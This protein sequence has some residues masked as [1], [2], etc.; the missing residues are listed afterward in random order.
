METTCWHTPEVINEM[1]RFYDLY[2]GNHEV[3]KHFNIFTQLLTLTDER[4][5][6]LLDLGCGTAMLS[7]YCKEYKYIGAD[8]PHIISGC[9]MRN[10][11]KY[12]FR[13]CDL[14]NDDLSWIN[15]Y[16]VISMNAVIDVM[17]DPIQMLRMV[18]T[19]AAKYIIIH[20]QEITE[21]GKTH[22][23]LKPSYNSKT[24]HSVISREDLNNLLEE[25]N[26]DIV[27]ELPLYFGDW[28][29][30]GCSLLL[31]KRRSWS[32]YDIDHKLSKYLKDIKNGFFVEAGANDG[33]SQSNSNYYEFYKNWKGLLIEPIEELY[34]AC[35]QNRSRQTIVENCALVSTLYPEKEIDII[36]TPG[37]NGLMSVIDGKNSYVQLAKAKEKGIHRKVTAA[38]LNS[39]F[40]KH[41]IEHI[42]IL[43]L[44]V[45]G[46]ETEVL[47]GIDFVKYPIT[48][49]L[50]EELEDNG[51]VEKY[52]KPWYTRI[53]QLTH[54]DYLYKRVY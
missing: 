53:D 27:K 4:G 9:A 3:G 45:E 31:R 16:P 30:G 38:T 41:N 1:N 2:K 21:K 14:L 50:I 23:L 28:E 22:S 46:Y 5:S 51:Q 35:L 26:F 37:C 13:G 12:F 39:L 52:L 47:Q 10:Y 18:L 36:Y 29:N 7:E 6:E 32:L 43:M 49:L 8:L 20:R 17:Q 24:W 44:D 54:H 15:K 25:Y 19:H 42:D 34:Q 11:R 33:L 48:Y 40:E